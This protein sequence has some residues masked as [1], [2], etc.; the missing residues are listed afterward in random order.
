MARILTL[1]NPKT[2]ARFSISRNAQVGR[3]ATL[4]WAVDERERP[5]VA[6]SLEVAV[7]IKGDEHMSRNH[8]AFVVND[9]GAIVHDLNSTNGTYVNE[10]RINSIE[11]VPI[12]SGDVIRFGGDTFLEVE[13]PV[14]KSDMAYRALLVGVDGGNLRGVENDLRVLKSLLGDRGFGDI[15]YLHNMDARVSRVLN[16]LDKAIALNTSPDHFL[17]YFSGHGLSEGICLQDG[18]IS[19]SALYSRLENVRGKKLVIVDSCYSGSFLTGPD[20]LP[21]ELPP[22]TLVIVAS[23]AERK[24]YERYATQSGIVLGTF[25]AGF[26]KYVENRPTKFNLA[27]LKRDIGTERFSMKDKYQFKQGPEVDGATCFT[28]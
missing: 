4:A 24:A 16:E 18:V 20:G 3:N 9:L 22:K 7:T 23:D 28:I 13:G 12:K 8:A 17:F 15:T 26:I 2:G 10:T 25:T 1:R 14:L 6:N 11:G 5:S 19:P 21:R 27:D